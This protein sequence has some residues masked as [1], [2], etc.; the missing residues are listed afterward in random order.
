MPV[1]LP[2]AGISTNLLPLLTIG[3]LIGLLSG[4]TGVG[5]GF[6]LTPMLMM[7]GVP[8]MISAASGCNSIVATSACAAGAHFRL[9]NVDVKLGT[10]ALIGG[11]AG[12]AVGVEIMKVLATLG[13]ANLLIRLTYVV[14]LGGIG[15]YMFADGY[16]A[17]RRP[18][19]AVESSGGGTRAF[20]DRLPWQVS[21]P[22][23]GVRHSILVPLA[24]CS[25][26]GILTAVMGV[27][28]GFLLVP[29][30]IYLLRIPL[31]MAVGT[32]LFQ[33]LFTGVGVTYMQAVTNT[34]VDLE[35]A[36]LVGA[37]STLGAQLGV[38]LNR[39]MRG[40]HLKILLAALALVVCVKMGADLIHPP[41]NLLSHVTVVTP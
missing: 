32:S 15:S 27:G 18:P 28:G 31:R 23:S 41:S 25:V 6:L 8:P 26:V 29:M 10:V 4:L 2:I 1:F 30:L 9:G 40:E 5:G 14:M 35:L 38:Q 33:I 39:H 16:R 19:A 36:L 34:T 13:E 24:L 20:L 3:A 37:G 11:L 17:L 22:R 21:F 7:I 12:S